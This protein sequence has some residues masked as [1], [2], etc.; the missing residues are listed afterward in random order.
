MTNIKKH[1]DSLTAVLIIANG[2]VP[3]VTIGTD[4]ALSMLSTIFP[5]AVTNNLAFL[6]TNVSSPLFLNFSQDTLPGFHKDAPPFLLDN[7]IALQKKFLEIKDGP[8]VKMRKAKFHKLIKT[9]EQSALEML[10]DFFDRLDSLEPRSITDIDP[11]YKAPQNITESLAPME[12]AATKEKGPTVSFHNWC[13][14]ICPV[15]DAHSFSN[16]QK[17]IP[18]PA[19]TQRPATNHDFF[20]TAPDCH[21]TCSPQLPLILTWLINM[22]PWLKFV[23]RSKCAHPHPHHCHWRSQR[24]LEPV[25]RDAVTDPPWPVKESAGPLSSVSPSIRDDE[26]AHPPKQGNADTEEKG[27]S[28][29]QLECMRNSSEQKLGLLGKVKERMRKGIQKIKRIF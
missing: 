12:T 29:Y 21:T 3:R 13:S 2:T 22:I 5:N 28:Q 14:D 8:D 24:D 16:F 19:S 27:I 1:V 26:A 6:F 25:R 18:A 7:P 4:Y 15:N 17:S 9:S 23:R 20:C 10:V 11:L